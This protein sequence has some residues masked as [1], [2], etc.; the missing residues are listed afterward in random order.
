MK[1]LCR[2][3]GHFKDC[4]GFQIA[5]PYFD[6]IGRARRT[7]TTRCSWCGEFYR[8]GSVIDPVLHLSSEKGSGFTKHTGNDYNVER[9][10]D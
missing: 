9:Q 7:L 3:F 5:P 1:L 8:V 2:L 10:N 4:Y 6:E